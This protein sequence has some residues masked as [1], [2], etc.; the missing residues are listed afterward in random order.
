MVDFQNAGYRLLSFKYIPPTPAAGTQ[1]NRPAVKPEG[2]GVQAADGDSLTLSSLMNS[3]QEIK[4]SDSAEPEN[5]FAVALDEQEKPTPF[6]EFPHFTD[7][8]AEIRLKIWALSF[9]PRVVEIRPTW[10]NYSRDSNEEAREPQWQSGNSNPAALSVSVEAREAALAHFCIPFPLAFVPPIT[11]TTPTITSRS[12]TSSNTPPS[13]NPFLPQTIAPAPLRLIYT[14]PDPSS[15]SS[16]PSPKARPLR[17]T[18]HL[19]PAHDT[20]CL[21]RQDSDPARLGQCISTFRRADP[22]GTGL[23][24]L[25]LSVRGYGYGGSAVALRALGQQPDGVL[26]SLTQL[27]LFMYGEHQ[28]PARWRER[29]EGSGGNDD[30][31][32]K[33]GQ[34]NRCALVGCDDMGSTGHGAY[35][36]WNQGV[37]RQFWDGEGGFMRFGRAGREIQVLDLVFEKGW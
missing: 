15:S 6:A 34:G 7:L 32:G 25:G 24:R 28:P 9:H 16:S 4:D 36:V 20:V 3:L 27:V 26:S 1:Q 2:A 19:S 30:G 12:P 37:G 17:R 10:P 13:T 22:L 29:G 11:T 33:A 23:E 35:T 18:L 8:P 5:V 21:L 14:H 31:G